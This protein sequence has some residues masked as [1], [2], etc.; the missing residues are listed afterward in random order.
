MTWGLAKP[1]T[2]CLGTLARMHDGL[3]FCMR[4]EL[5]RGQVYHVHITPRDMP[6]P[7][8]HAH[9]AGLAD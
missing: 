9:A 1:G 3:A 7:R 2:R 4:D 6:T 5:T 8:P